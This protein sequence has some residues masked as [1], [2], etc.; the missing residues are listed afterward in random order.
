M[1]HLIHR[2]YRL[3]RISILH[4]QHSSGPI[5]K[6]KHSTWLVHFSTQK[7]QTSQTSAARTS[8]PPAITTLFSSI[9]CILDE[10][11]KSIFSVTHLERLLLTKNEIRL[12]ILHFNHGNMYSSMSSLSSSCYGSILSYKQ[13]DTS[14]GLFGAY[15]S[16]V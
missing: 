9:F 12:L 6:V 1:S 3:H 15:Q 10:Q 11:Q 7:L 4:F 8:Y 2:L 16:V 5:S 13:Y 14:Q